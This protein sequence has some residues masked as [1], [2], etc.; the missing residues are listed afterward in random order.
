[1]HVQQRDH[2]GGLGEKQIEPGAQLDTHDQCPKRGNGTKT[3]A[4]SIG[5]GDLDPFSQVF[6][7]N[8]W[9]IRFFLRNLFCVILFSLWMEPCPCLAQLRADRGIRF[10][11]N[12]MAHRRLCLFFWRCCGRGNSFGFRCA[13]GR[14]GLRFQRTHVTDVLLGKGSGIETGRGRGLEKEKSGA[15]PVDDKGCARHKTSKRD[16]KAHR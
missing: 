10:I 11:E 12:R 15:S 13:F 16:G 5:T 3:V 9:P 14:F 4:M 8:L 2:R 6:I 7:V 1:M